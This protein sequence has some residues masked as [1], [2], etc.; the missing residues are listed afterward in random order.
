MK[1]LSALIFVSLS[2]VTS[3]LNS[4]NQ[5]TKKYEESIEKHE[6]RGEV[7]LPEFIYTKSVGMPCSGNTLDIRNKQIRYGDINPGTQIVIKDNQDTIIGVG[8][9]EQGSLGK[10]TLDKDFPSIKWLSCSFPFKITNLP[11]S[12]F[13]SVEIL[14]R[15][16]RVVY[17][18]QELDKKDWQV[19]M[20]IK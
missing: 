18:F 2:I 15:N 14:N 5:S 7:V 6:I 17:S 16:S 12:E 1:I 20:T 11:R 8:V 19:E 4:C 9:L 10:E 13:Y 3:F